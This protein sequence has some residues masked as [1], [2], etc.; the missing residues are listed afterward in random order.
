M[1]LGHGVDPAAQDN[2]GMTGLHWAAANGHVDVVKLLLGQGAPLE[3]RN[4]WGGT[5]L[6][7]T[8]YFARHYPED[9]AAYAAMIGLLLSAGAEVRAVEYP[10]GIAPI[11]E[12]LGEVLRRHGAT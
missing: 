4:A 1:L 2:Q 7:S 8:L 6:G 5:V 10:T 9:A 11:D 3:T 12:L